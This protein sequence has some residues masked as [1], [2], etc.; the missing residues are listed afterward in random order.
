MKDFMLVKFRIIG[1]EPELC[2]L[3]ER[4]AGCNVGSSESGCQRFQLG[5]SRAS[6]PLPDG[7]NKKNESSSLL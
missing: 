1:F 6:E 4:E 5:T 7:I 2:H 3:S